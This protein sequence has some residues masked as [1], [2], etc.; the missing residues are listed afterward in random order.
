[1]G[2]GQDGIDATIG[3]QQ[4]T[5]N[6]SLAAPPEQEKQPA[7]ATTQSNTAAEIDPEK[8]LPNQDAQHG[9][10]RA[11]A[12]SIVWT[13]TQMRLVLC[14]I[15][16]LY[17]VTAFEQQLSGNLTAYV[18]S[19]FAAHSLIP[20]MYTV[21]DCM[22]A[23]FRMP[24]AKMLDIWGRAEGF[25]VMATV[26]T[27]GMVMMAACQNVA[28]YAA[29]QAFFN[30]GFS[31]M[32]FAV[33]VVTADISSLKHRGLA[34]AITSSPYII[35]AFAGPKASEAFYEKINFRWG[36]G[37]FAI[38]LPFV[39][40]LVFTPLILN[41]R[42][43]QKAGILI[44]EENNRNLLQSI[45]YF[46]TEVDVAG[47]I[48]LAGGL[49]L[50]LL[51]FELAGSE[52]GQWKSA[53]IICMLVLG[54]ILLALFCINERF[55]APKPFLPYHLLLSRTVIGTCLLSA[56]F[57]VAYYC[58]GSY[59][60]SYLQVVHQVSISEAGYISSSYDVV[61]GVFDFFVGYMISRTGRFKWLLMCAAPLMIL[62]MGL[63][64]YFRQPG[65]HVGYVVMCQVFIAL[66]GG[67]ITICAQVSIMAHAAHENI[68]ALLAFLGLFSYIG[69]GIGNSVSGAI[70]THTLPQA[71]E[72][73]LPANETAADPTLMDTI[74][75]DLTVQ[76]SYGYGS[77]ERT[78][79]VDSYAIAQKRMLIAGTAFMA[80]SLLWVALIKNLRVD[81]VKQTKGIVF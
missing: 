3:T 16:L 38:I 8:E 24:I 65:T 37:I 69:G 41:Q 66:A 62:G 51:P 74:Y 2:P 34:Y 68:A 28:T 1:M 27:I 36:F 64:I 70:W 11:E 59:F 5:D 21:S 63:M 58:W 30:V 10:K 77:V 31:G 26:S 76:L 61:A 6:I 4:P 44:K 73:L 45:W 14:S 18:T 48:L 52:D 32:I 81:K 29:A 53:K 54:I 22:S 57:Q 35:T 50:F 7:G 13:K 47:I 12:V 46:I 71:L 23:A 55:W 20:V 15:I 19:G 40:L 39:A 43:A 17:F 25:A 49:V 79:I 78:A 42:K 33:D 56:T 72:R 80:L 67:T 75:E 60:T 9:V